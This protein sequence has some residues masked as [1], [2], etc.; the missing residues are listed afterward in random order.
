MHIAHIES[1]LSRKILAGDYPAGERLPSI[2]TLAREL[3]ASYV[4]VQK[5]VKSLEGKGLI[6]TE[7]GKGS[8][9]TK[10]GVR[11]SIHAMG[12]K[13]LLY[14]FADPLVNVPDEYELELYHEFQS[15][16]RGKGYL[17]RM[18]LPGELE[19][20]LDADTAISGA[21]VTDFNPFASR[22][23]TRGIPFVYCTSIPVSS[24]DPSVNPDFHM[25]AKLATLHLRELG[26]DDIRFVSIPED[27]PEQMVNT[28][29]VR[30]DGYADA[31]DSSGLEAKPPMKWHRLNAS[32][33]LRAALKSKKRPSAILV[34]NDVMAV[35][36]MQMAIEIGLRVPEDLSIA[37][38][39]DM[40]CSR[41]STPQLTTAGY[42]KKTLAG[43]TVGL[44][45][46]IIE[47]GKPSSIR[48]RVPM[49]L[50]LR[51]STA[52]RA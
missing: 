17:D 30:Y 36:I 3:D 5:A 21:V 39:E 41:Q 31:M 47:G 33:E 22:L 23:R 26:H 42:D 1:A 12:A 46:E 35:E 34:A 18:L 6:R 45:M 25:G 4:T 48:R 49:R 44:L 16:A 51:G 52:K 13:E 29:V 43:E 11:R 15:L 32:S 19:E 14:I 27:N 8:F 38:L 37:G 40:R 20:A 10:L 9:I 7:L 50:V 2:R 24:S 28:F